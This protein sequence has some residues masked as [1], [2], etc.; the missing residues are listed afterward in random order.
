MN[1]IVDSHT[2][3]F[4]VSIA[5]DVSQRTHR[6]SRTSGNH[7]DRAISIRNRRKGRSRW[8]GSFDVS[9]DHSIPTFCA[10]VA[11]STP[12]RTTLGLLPLIALSAA[13]TGP[14]MAQQTTTTTTT[15]T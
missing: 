9:G 7:T 2:H 1:L 10:P 4:M 5:D 13:L 14:A 3:V 11:P 12:M 8:D 15:T 6:A